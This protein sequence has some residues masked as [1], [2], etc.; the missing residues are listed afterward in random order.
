M[1]IEGR[2]VWKQWYPNLITE[3]RAVLIDQSKHRHTFAGRHTA[4]AFIASVWTDR[5]YKGYNVAS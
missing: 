5:K 3:A 2:N 4:T 1:Y